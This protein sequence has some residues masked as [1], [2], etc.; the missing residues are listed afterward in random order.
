MHSTHSLRASRAA[1][2]GQP[3]RRSEIYSKTA[4]VPKS[5]RDSVVVTDW[6]G[7]EE[8]CDWRARNKFVDGKILTAAFHAIGRQETKAR[9]LA[10][11][12]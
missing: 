11:K 12:K 1:I 8:R 3:R 4:I 5:V 7:K 2:E 6:W 10:R 9:A